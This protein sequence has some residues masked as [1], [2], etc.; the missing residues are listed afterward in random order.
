MVML[1]A[2]CFGHAREDAQRCVTMAE[3][4]DGVEHLIVRER[5]DAGPCSEVRVSSLCSPNANRC[6]PSIFLG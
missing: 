2:K 1:K 3:E 4:G 6:E 5:Q